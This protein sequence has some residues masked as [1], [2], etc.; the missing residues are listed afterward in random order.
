MNINQIA[1]CILLATFAGCATSRTTTDRRS[2][3]ASACAGVPEAERDTNPLRSGR[4]L[5]V[6][7]LREAPY[8]GRGPRTLRGATV[9]LAASPG[10]TQQWLQRLFEC[11]A[12]RRA[13]EGP[14]SIAE[15][16]CPLNL[17]IEAPTVSALADSFAVSLRTDDSD[18]AERLVRKC[19]ALL[20]QP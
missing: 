3:A 19:L 10:M 17:A 8:T 6:Q 18:D 2:A 1:V 4:V 12:A 11:N 7:P 14:A 13:L 15:D 20:V 16:P 9:I 5:A